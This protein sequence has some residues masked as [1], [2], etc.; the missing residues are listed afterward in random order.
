MSLLVFPVAERTESNK[1][2]GSHGREWSECIFHLREETV[3]A[4]SVF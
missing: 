3:F 1:P 4:E 2:P